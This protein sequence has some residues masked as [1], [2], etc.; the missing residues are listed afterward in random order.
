L[1]EQSVSYGVFGLMK[2]V[3]KIKE[4]KKVMIIM[5][6]EV[7]DLNGEKKV[8]IML[9]MGNVFCY[10]RRDVKKMS[11]GNLKDSVKG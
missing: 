9:L 3:V 4:V 5:L 7:V 8:K 11:M 6:D 1:V 10:C 2:L